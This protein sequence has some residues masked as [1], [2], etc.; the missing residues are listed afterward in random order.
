[1]HEV[2]ELQELNQVSGVTQPN[3]GTDTLLSC[4]ARLSRMETG[5]SRRLHQADTRVSLLLGPFVAT[6]CSDKGQ[7]S[8]K[9]RSGAAGGVTVATASVG[10]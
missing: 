3:N 5:S 10:H 1:M 6:R 7:P 9:T 4:Q 8:I 2:E